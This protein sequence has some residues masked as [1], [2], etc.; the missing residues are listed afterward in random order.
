MILTY[1]QFCN[2]LTGRE[3]LGARESILPKSLIKMCTSNKLCIV[4]K[5]KYIFDGTF[6][7][8]KNIYNIATKLQ[9]HID[10]NYNNKLSIYQ[11]LEYIFHS[12]T[13]DT[14]IE[15]VAIFCPSYEGNGYKNRCGKTTIKK[16]DKL[17]ELSAFLDSVEVKH[18]LYL[19][20]ADIFLENTNT[21]LEPELYNQ[22]EVNKSDFKARVKELFGNESYIFLSEHLDNIREYYPTQKDFVVGFIDENIISAIK[23]STQKTFHLSSKNLYESFGWTIDE[24]LERNNKLMTIYTILAQMMS[25]GTSVI[26]L[27][28]ENMYKR[29]KI[30]ENEELCCWYLLEEN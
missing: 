13:N 7:L 1:S 11:T 27:P 26:Y 3:Q 14:P 18:N 9:G 8:V 17:K 4:D 21:D 19:V 25:K 29:A 16:L 24:M 23:P 12:L 6:E 28:M 5:Q 10:Y 22:L 15:L 20:F 30:F 2:E